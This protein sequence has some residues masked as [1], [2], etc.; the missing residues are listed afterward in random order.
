M[1]G[2]SRERYAFAM[3]QG[4]GAITDV[5]SS[6]EIIREMMDEAEAMIARM[7]ALARKTVANV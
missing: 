7:S 6:A 1:E 2:L 3:G 5:K 4:A